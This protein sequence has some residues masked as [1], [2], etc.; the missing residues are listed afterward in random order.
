[1]YPNRRLLSVSSELICDQPAK[2]PHKKRVT[3]K[4]KLHVLSE[5]KMFAAKT[6]AAKLEW[7]EGGE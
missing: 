3:K 1:M 6:P 5:L 4:E 2:K 7:V